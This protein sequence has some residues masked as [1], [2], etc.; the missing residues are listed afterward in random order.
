MVRYVASALG[1]LL[2]TS[3]L[4]LRRYLR[5]RRLEMPTEMA[6]AWLGV[7]AAMGVT[8]LVLAMLIPRPNP[9]YAISSITGSLGSPARDANSYAPLRDSPGQGKSSSTAPANDQTQLNQNP[10]SD[11]GQND[12]S[13]AAGRSNAGGQ[14]SGSTDQSQP[15]SGTA[16][17]GQ[18]QSGQQAGQQ[19]SGQQAGGA[20]GRG[21]SVFESAATVRPAVHGTKILRRIGGQVLSVARRSETIHKRPR[22]TASCQRKQGRST[23]GLPGGAA[24]DRAVA[25][26][27]SKVPHRRKNNSPAIKRRQTTPRQNNS[28]RARRR[29]GSN[30]RRSPGSESHGESV[31]VA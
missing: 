9:E 26:G 4:G 13:S 10:Q 17:S 5:Q 23:A 7:G 24:A 22:T 19:Q 8:I 27:T 28:R 11:Q 16:A 31:R 21:P 30:R 15:P 1:L 12:S 14:Q 3:F 20:A 18:Q 25:G 6:G 2:T 29:R